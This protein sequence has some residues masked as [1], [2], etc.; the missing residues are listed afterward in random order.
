MAAPDGGLPSRLVSG[1][2]EHP[3]ARELVLGPLPL[4]VDGACNGVP[5]VSCYRADVMDESA[6]LGC[7][8]A[9][10]C[11]QA[12]A[13]WQVVDGHWQ[14]TEV[15]AA[16]AAQAFVDSRTDFGWDSQWD[17]RDVMRG[18]TVVEAATRKDVADRWGIPLGIVS[19]G[20]P[21]VLDAGCGT[22]TLMLALETDRAFLEAL[23]D[24]DHAGA[25]LGGLAMGI[26]QSLAGP[27]GLE[28]DFPYLGLHDVADGWG[29]GGGTA[30]GGVATTA[31]L[32]EEFQ[33][34]WVQRLSIPH[35]LAH[36]ISGAAVGPALAQ[37]HALVDGQRAGGVHPLWGDAHG[38][39][40]L[41]ALV[42]SLLHG[43]GHNLGA[44]HTHEYCPPL[45]QCSPMATAGLCQTEQ[46]CR[47]DGTLMS[48]CH[49][50]PGGMGNVALSYHPR[51]LEAMAYD[52]MIALPPDQALTLDWDLAT[53]PWDS[54]TVDLG[55][56]LDLLEPPEVHLQQAGVWLGAYPMHAVSPWRYRWDWPGG[57]CGEDLELRLWIR[58]R[59]CGEFWWPDL[60][61][62]GPLVHRTR[63]T[64][65]AFE[66]NATRS[67]GWSSLA[68]T[69]YAGFWSRGIPVADPNWSYA[70]T[71]DAGGD[72]MC[73]LTGNYYGNSDVDGGSA[74]WLSPPLAIQEGPLRIEFDYF[75]GLTNQNGSDRL[76]L[77]GGITGSDGPWVSLWTTASDSAGWQHA[78]IEWRVTP[79]ASPRQLVVRFLATDGLPPSIVE[80][81]VDGFQVWHQ[82]CP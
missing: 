12:L 22:R 27:L 33:A 67:M 7:L 40:D 31:E 39:V 66:D 80:A 57:P 25:L 65:L 34:Q 9:A 74:E 70:P 77:Q 59:E 30:P 10:T 82:E 60:G 15:D 4:Y 43:L 6:P 51:N 2:R 24:V 69:A 28:V 42:R 29:A 75:L 48:F 62:D 18:C 13:V 72:G 61:L 56:A 37:S 5:P 17:S 32:F 50:C 19:S 52:V 44:R 78:T 79:P 41:D 58:S 55:T 49:L 81:A 3:V 47:S 73:F 14:S 21:L 26:E 38:A 35:H 64:S 1:G 8:L 54:W 68:H 16:G 11:G 23:G 20:V 36:L 53:E 76:E 71:T 46:E 63:L 45:D